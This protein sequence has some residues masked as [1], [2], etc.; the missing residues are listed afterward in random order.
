LKRSPLKRK[1]PLRAKRLLS[2]GPVGQLQHK[3]P[4]RR[5]PPRRLKGPGADAKYLELVRGLPCVLH[6]LWACSGPIE[7]HHAGKRGVGQKSRDDEA[8]P[9]CRWHHRCLTD[10]LGHFYG[11]TR[12]QRR[13]WH[14]QQIAA[15]RARLGR[16][17]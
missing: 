16:A 1:T 2:R 14:D 13:E 9:L 8:I 15:T 7:A 6:P 4:I 12:V 11:W 10:H 5:K 17:A 3:T